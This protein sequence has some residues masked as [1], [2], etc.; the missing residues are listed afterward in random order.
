MVKRPTA[1]PTKLGV[2]TAKHVFDRLA[3]KRA[4]AKMAVPVEHLAS[5]VVEGAEESEKPTKPRK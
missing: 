3:A 5:T 2:H 1:L 4:R